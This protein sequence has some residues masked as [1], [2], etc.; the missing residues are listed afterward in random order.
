MRLPDDLKAEV[1]GLSQRVP[2][3]ARRAS[4]LKRGLWLAV[5]VLGAVGLGLARVHVFG[6]GWSA[7]HR[8]G[9]FIVATAIGWAA[10]ALWGTWI[11]LGGRSMV[12]RPRGWL[13]AAAIGTPVLLL[14]WMLLWNAVFPSTFQACPGRPGRLC[15]DATTVVAGIPL[16]VVAL[17]ARGGTPVNGATRGAAMGAAFGAWAGLAVDLSCGCSDPLHVIR[18][19]LLPVIALALLGTAVGQWV[20]RLRR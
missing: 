13:L 6:N 16:L 4:D 12:P 8:P 20:L 2:S 9:G 5:G 18:G 19:H 10:V 3:P 14:G 1:L 17:L 7:D 11:A 15:F